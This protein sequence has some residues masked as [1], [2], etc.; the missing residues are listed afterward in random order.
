[1]KQNLYQLINDSN[2]DLYFLV[3]D[4]FL[5]INLPKLKNLKK[6]YLSDYPSI[7]VKNSGKLLSHPSVIK[8]IRE[9]SKK[10]NH[11]P[12]IIPFKPS[13]KIDFIC[14]KEKWVCI[15][16]SSSLNRILEDKIKFTE[17]CKLYNLPQIPFFTDEFNEDNYKKYLEKF[18]KMVIQTHFGWAGKSTYFSTSWED[19]KSKIAIGTHV[20]FLPFLEGFT[21]LNNC[22][23]TKFGLIQSPPALQYTGLKHFTNNPFTTVGRQWPSLVS[24]EILKKVQDITKNFSSILSQYNY[25]GFFGLDFLVSEKQV[26]LLECNPRLTASFDFYTQIEEKQNLTPLFLFHLA[27]FLKLDY[28]ID[29]TAE[30]KRFENKKIVGSELVKR[31]DKNNPIQK[32]NRFIAFSNSPDPITIDPQIINLFEK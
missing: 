6:I 17:I 31:D 5:D 16:N 1:M 4:N 22:C 3:V 11:T 25:K 20:K 29:I 7:K 28:E 27:E 9:N 12:A 32:I 18:K 8:F 30:Q 10:N 21:L 24:K 23:L 19:I 14:K 15:G 26:F 13:A 2:F